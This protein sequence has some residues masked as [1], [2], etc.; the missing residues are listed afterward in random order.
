[1]LKK[2]ILLIIT[3]SI[4]AYKTLYLI[5]LLKDHNYEINTIMTSSAKKFITPLSVSSLSGNKIYED[6]FDLTDETEM[7]HINLAKIH[8]LILVV[9]ASANFISKVACGLSDNLASS[10]I[11]ATR[12]KI[13]SHLL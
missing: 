2:K 6:L 1:M 8:D 5:R 9:P 11:L 12:K 13:F 7:G 10:V 3:G 4:A